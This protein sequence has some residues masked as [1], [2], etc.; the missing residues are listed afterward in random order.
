MGEV[1]RQINFASF[2]L[3]LYLPTTMFFIWTTS[4]TLISHT[5]HAYNRHIFSSCQQVIRSNKK[6]CLDEELPCCPSHHF[7]WS[8]RNSSC[9]RPLLR[10][11]GGLV[12]RRKKNHLAN[13]TWNWS[14]SSHSIYVQKK[15]SNFCITNFITRYLVILFLTAFQLTDMD[16]KDI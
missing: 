5:W 3:S 2:G 8:N 13:Q 11:R 12:C 14:I 9:Y 15:P 4:K 16:F 6:V 7:S 1:W 10:G